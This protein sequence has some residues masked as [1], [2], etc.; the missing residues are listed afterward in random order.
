LNQVVIGAAASG[1]CGYVS[2]FICRM[3]ER[4]DEGI[5]VADGDIMN[6]I[7][8]KPENIYLHIFLPN[9]LDENVLNEIREKQALL[10][11]GRVLNARSRPVEFYCYFEDEDLH[12]VD[13]PTNIVT[14][15]D[16][17][18]TILEMEADDIFDIRASDRFV[19]KEMMLYESTLN[20]ILNSKFIQQ[21]I[22]EQYYGISETELNEMCNKILDI[23]SNRLTI[24]MY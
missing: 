2:N 13:Y 23:V 20:T 15:Y 24:M 12:I 9:N 1:A 22:K 17:A 6:T 18:R 14:S 19:S 10:T 16:T 4:I 8:V 11:R 5:E 21:V 3:L 7:S